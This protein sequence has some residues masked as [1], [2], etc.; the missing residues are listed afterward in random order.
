MS[1][2][3][4][5]SND[6]THSQPMPVDVLYR[7]SQFHDSIQCSQNCQALFSGHHIIRRRLQ[8]IVAHVVFGISNIL[9]FHGIIVSI[10][11]F[12]IVKCRPLER[13]DAKNDS[14]S[15]RSMCTSS[16]RFC[17]RFERSSIFRSRRS[18]RI[19]LA[20]FSFVD[21]I[22]LSAICAPRV[23][24]ARSSRRES[25][26]DLKFIRRCLP[27]TSAVS[28]LFVFSRS[29]NLCRSISSCIASKSLGRSAKRALQL[30]DQRHSPARR[31]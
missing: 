22:L 21:E 27:M 6:L 25:N 16:F 8:K 10:G 24:P 31:T 13:A 20:P 29:T 11:D 3:T 23:S 19:A 5:P 30:G 26:G 9:R 7:I 4:Q 1:K 28:F 17:R 18:T 15:G 14:E 12:P 2:Y